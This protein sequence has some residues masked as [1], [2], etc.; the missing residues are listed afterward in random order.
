MKNNSSVA[1][2]LTIDDNFASVSPLEF[3]RNL[4]TSSDREYVRHR[5]KDATEKA[6]AETGRGLDLKSADLSGMNLGGMDLRGSMLNRAVLHGAILSDADLSDANI[7]CPAMEKT[8]LRRVKL[9]RGYIHAIAAQVCDFREA[10][11]QGLVDATGGLFHGCNLA[12]VNFR[13]S[14]LAGTTFY[15]CDLRESS[16]EAASLQGA[17]INE[18]LLDGA[19][20]QAADVSQLTITKCHMN[21]VDFSRASGSACTVQNP[22]AAEKLSFDYGNLPFLRLLGVRSSSLSARALNAGN[23]EISNCALP[24]AH[25]EEANLSGA[26]ILHLDAKSSSF[27]SA[28]LTNAQILNSQ[29]DEIDLSACKAENLLAVQS[30]FRNAHLVSFSGRC[31]VFRDCDLSLANLEGIY[32]YRAMITGDP[33]VAMSLVGVNAKGA[34]LVQAYIAADL[35]SASLCNAR[36]AY[37]RF[38]QSSFR[39]ADLAGAGFYEASMVKTDFSGARMTHVS[40]PFFAD[41]CPG[42]EE[43]LTRDGCTETLD[44]VSHLRLAM[45]IGAKGST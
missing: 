34:V 39:N 44:F 22:T 29:L 30:S 1:Q 35:T 11:L 2:V 41:R 24:G 4:A 32:L 10:S 28:K 5:T 9:D 3:I 38:N 16:W 23:V 36:C 14:N 21:Q 7:I 43:A 33:P 25:F 8:D 31:A 26:R 19:R 13:A 15:Q 37:A 20:F 6:L 45:R 17:T 40:P 18:C 42:L 12:G 27:C